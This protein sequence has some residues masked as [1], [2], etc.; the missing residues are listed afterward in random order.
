MTIK[1]IKHCEANFYSYML[2]IDVVRVSLIQIVDEWISGEKKFI[3]LK[4]G[5]TFHSNKTAMHA[6][7]LKQQL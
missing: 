4:M 7:H 1:W 3:I 2:F 5:D 6:G